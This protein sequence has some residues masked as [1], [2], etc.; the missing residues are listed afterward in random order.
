MAGGLT[1]KAAEDCAHSGTLREVEGAP[2]KGSGP[3]VV[4]HAG[5]KPATQQTWMSAPP[6][7]GGR[8]L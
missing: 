6:G 8:F 4:R 3:V 5:W 1:A 2:A 7:W